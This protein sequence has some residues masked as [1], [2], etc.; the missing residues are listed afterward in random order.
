MP[1]VDL[2]PLVGKKLQFK[3][4]EIDTVR[5]RISLSLKTNPEAGIKPGTK[6]SDGGKDDRGNRPRSGGSNNNF[7]KGPAP[8][9]LGSFLKQPLN[10]K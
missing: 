10:L 8:G 5:K 9:S 4:I 6:P 3:I 1:P 2:A 7:N